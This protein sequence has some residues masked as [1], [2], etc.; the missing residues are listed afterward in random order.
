VGDGPL[1]GARARALHDPLFRIGPVVDFGPEAIPGVVAWLL[2][3]ASAVL[4][5][6]ARRVALATYIV[7]CLLLPWSS[8]ASVGRSAALAF[9]VA[10]VLAGRPSAARPVL[11]FTAP[12][13]VFSC[14]LYVLGSSSD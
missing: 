4:L 12:L 7:A 14:L 9:P 13:V 6:R 5:V 8:L 2:A 1:C 11:L 3:L 10:L